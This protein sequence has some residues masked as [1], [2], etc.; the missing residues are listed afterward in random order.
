[1]EYQI[2][3]H[4]LKFSDPSRELLLWIHHVPDVRIKRGRQGEPSCSQGTKWQAVLE[5]WERGKKYKR[6]RR[7]DIW[8]ETEWC[9]G[10][11]N[12]PGR[13]KYCTGP[14][15]L[16]SR[17]FLAYRWLSYRL[18][19]TAARALNSAFP[20]SLGG[21]GHSTQ[22]V[23]STLQVTRQPLGYWGCILENGSFSVLV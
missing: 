1:M 3:P 13:H 19:D 4:N 14:S 18:S 11:L 20:S 7:G 5:K 2:L 15:L 8:A 12:S 16:W 23:M 10:P 17:F 9:D 21:L 22:R 6:D